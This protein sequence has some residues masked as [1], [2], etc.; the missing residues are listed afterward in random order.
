MSVA[1]GTASVKKDKCVVLNFCKNL[2]AYFLW[3]D[4]EEWAIWIIS[5]F[6]FASMTFLYDNMVIHF[7]KKDM[8]QQI[9]KV[10]T[11]TV[12]FHNTAVVGW[13]V[14]PKTHSVPCDQ[15]NIKN[16]E[17]GVSFGDSGHIWTACV[18]VSVFTSECYVLGLFF[19][20]KV[21]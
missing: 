19:T 7:L 10:R 17:W 2:T 20:Q 13:R 9:I 5:S 18:S 3:T 14:F 12:S 8:S 15:K 16:P 1:I 6:T 4:N 21:G 11:G